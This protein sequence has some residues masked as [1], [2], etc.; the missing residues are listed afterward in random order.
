MSIRQKVTKV[1][2]LKDMVLAPSRNKKRLNLKIDQNAIP[3]G[4]ADKELS[5]LQFHRKLG[6]CVVNF[7][8]K[9]WGKCRIAPPPPPT[10]CIY[11][12]LCI[13]VIFS[14]K[15]SLCSSSYQSAEVQIISV[16]HQRRI[17][18]RQQCHAF[19]FEQVL[20]CLYLQKRF[21]KVSRKKCSP[22][23]G[24]LYIR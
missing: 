24:V 2:N 22:E 6:F 20:R 9:R 8:V 4:P 3:R 19:P 5:K 21:G 14:V 10:D 12:T 16:C 1:K 7:I 23:G 17:L 15:P 18:F 11:I 13:H